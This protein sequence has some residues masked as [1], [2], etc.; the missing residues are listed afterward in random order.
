VDVT[1]TVHGRG[2]ENNSRPSRDQSGP[3]EIDE[4]VVAEVIDR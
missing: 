3:Q 4:R 2:D 1:L